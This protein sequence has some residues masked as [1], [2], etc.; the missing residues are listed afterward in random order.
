MYLMF[1]RAY[2]SEGETRHMYQGHFSYHRIPCR[3]LLANE[4]RLRPNG[5]TNTQPNDREQKGTDL[6]R[7]AKP[8]TLVLKIQRRSQED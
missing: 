2:V 5:T 7:K 6:N 1:G 4:R 8:L 3:K